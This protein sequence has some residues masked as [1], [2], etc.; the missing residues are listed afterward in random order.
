VVE[1]T[2]EGIIVKVGSI[3]HP[4]EEKHYIEWVEV[5]SGERLFVK[6]FLSGEKPEATFPL[7]DTNVK[8]RIYCNVH[9]LWTNTA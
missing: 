1:K 5:R 4:M 9:G 8:V 3:P 6:G 7:A 2:T